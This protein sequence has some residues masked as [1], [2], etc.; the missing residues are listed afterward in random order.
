MAE[1]DDIKNQ[2]Q[3]VFDSKRFY[4]YGLLVEE[5]NFESDDY[6]FTLYVDEENENE[7]CIKQIYSIHEDVEIRLT[8][9][10]EFKLLEILKLDK[11]R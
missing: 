8:V 6:I 2:L 3:D 7:I 11:T 4:L 1:F 9:D 10:L 5:V